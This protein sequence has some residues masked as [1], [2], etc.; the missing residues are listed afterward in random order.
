MGDSTYGDGYHG[1]HHGRSPGGPWSP[2]REAGQNAAWTHQAEAHKKRTMLTNPDVS[3]PEWS[4]FKP[5]PSTT[6]HVGVTPPPGSL[7]AALIGDTTLGRGN[8]F[9]AAVGTI[10]GFGFG[11]LQ[12]F[13]T[14]PGLGPGIALV[15]KSTVIGAACGFFLLL[16]LVAAACIALLLI[17]LW[18]LATLLNLL[19]G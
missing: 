5:P 19:A 16:G 7:R 10:G 17:V 8:R 6:G 13:T 1:S 2:A 4:N 9:F 18:S 11:L 14:A 12:A 15:L 3:I